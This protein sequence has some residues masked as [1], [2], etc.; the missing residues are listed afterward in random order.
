MTDYTINCVECGTPWADVPLAAAALRLARAVSVVRA[1]WVHPDLKATP[2]TARQR[3]VARKFT[4]ADDEE[5]A[6][7][8]A[9][10][11]LEVDDADLR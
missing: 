3:A 10:R 1:L 5:D 9:F 6:A 2:T 7:L 4:I 8:A 11:A